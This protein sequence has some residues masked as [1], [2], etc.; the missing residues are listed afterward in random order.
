MDKG[1]KVR[2]RRNTEVVWEGALA[3]LKNG[4]DDVMDVK[5][6]AECGVGFEG[7]EG[8]KVGDVMQC[9]SEVVVRRE[10]PMGF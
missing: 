10:L 5:S 3:S 2:V 1:S 9:V 8:F 6:G 4:R 7:G